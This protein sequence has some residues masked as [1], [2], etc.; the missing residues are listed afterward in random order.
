MPCA[1][2]NS[3]ILSFCSSCCTQSRPAYS[4]SHTY[5]STKSNM[6]YSCSCDHSPP[7][8]CLPAAPVPASK[9]CCLCHSC[10]CEPFSHPAGMCSSFFEFSQHCCFIFGG[11]YKWENCEHSPCSS[12]ISRELFSSWWKCCCQ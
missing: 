6:P 3:L 5:T 8:C 4:S 1:K 7:F 9:Y 12:R 10:E 2:L 11:R